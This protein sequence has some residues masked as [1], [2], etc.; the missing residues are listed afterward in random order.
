VNLVIVCRV[1]HGIVSGEVNPKYG[2]APVTAAA[3][4]I[5]I[6][7]EVKCTFDIVARKQE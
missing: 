6:K 4:A 1:P 3:G 7:D 2:I 5:R